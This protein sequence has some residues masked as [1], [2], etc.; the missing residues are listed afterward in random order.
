MYIRDRA[1]LKAARVA[2]RK[3][4]KT[5]PIWRRANRTVPPRSREASPGEGSRTLRGPGGVD[6][7]VVV[8]KQAARRA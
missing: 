6:R 8:E 1:R 2:I 4:Y 7:P 5:N 3:I